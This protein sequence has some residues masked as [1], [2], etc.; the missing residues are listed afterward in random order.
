MAYT[1]GSD[2][3]A[4]AVDLGS[5]RSELDGIPP[6]KNDQGSV[7]SLL[8]VAPRLDK[9]STQR[10]QGRTPADRET[11]AQLVLDL[12]D[13]LHQLLAT[14]LARALVDGVHGRGQEEPYRLVDVCFCGHGRQRDLGEGLAD[15]H[16]R[17]ELPHR[18]RDGR[19]RVGVQLGVVHLSS[20]RDKVRRELLGR[21]WGEAW[22]AFSGGR[23]ARKHI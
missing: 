11:P 12:G 23:G 19:P 6:L 20:D 15:A 22:C 9:L 1:Y 4:A 5:L 14:A 16:D 2:S 18:D 7:E 10:R 17:L 21:F 3:D 8:R 13:F